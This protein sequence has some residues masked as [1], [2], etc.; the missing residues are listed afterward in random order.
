M[1]IIQII[2]DLPSKNLLSLFILYV[3]KN[4]FLLEEIFTIEDKTLRLVYLF[5]FI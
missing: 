2:K 1:F 4:N 5:F 3:K